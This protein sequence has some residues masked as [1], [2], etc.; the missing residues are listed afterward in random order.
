MK[1]NYSNFINSSFGNSRFVKKFASFLIMLNLLTTFCLF[2][3]LDLK[4]VIVRLLGYFL[5]TIFTF[6]IIK[7]IAP[8]MIRSNEKLFGVNAPLLSRVIFLIA[9]FQ[10]FLIQILYCAEAISMLIK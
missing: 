9:L 5:M 8:A 10:F 4:Y 2:Y 7:F 1:F 3:K 6:V